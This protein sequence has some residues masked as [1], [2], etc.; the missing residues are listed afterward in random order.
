MDDKVQPNKRKYSSFTGISKEPMELAGHNAAASPGSTPSRRVPGATGTALPN[1]AGT[2]AAAPLGLKLSGH[3]PKATRTASINAS[4]PNATTLPSLRPSG[5]APEATGIA[6]PNV[7]GTSAPTGPDLQELQRGIA[8]LTQQ[9]RKTNNML[10]TISNGLAEHQERISALERPQLLDP[11]RRGTGQI[12]EPAPIVFPPGRAPVVRPSHGPP[13]DFP[14]GHLMDF[15]HGPSMSLSLGAPIG[16]PHGSS[17]GL[18]LGAPVSFS[19]GLPNVQATSMRGTVP[20][21]GNESSGRLHLSTRNV[22]ARSDTNLSAAQGRL[23]STVRQTASG[24]DVASSSGTLE[25]RVFPGLGHV[26]L[27]NPSDLKVFKSLLG[28]SFILDLFRSTDK[29]DGC[30]VYTVQRFSDFNKLLCRQRGEETRIFEHSQQS[31]WSD[32]PAV[33][34]LDGRKPASPVLAFP[35][36]VLDLGEVF[37]WKRCAETGQKQQRSSGFHLVMDV[38]RPTK[39][40]WLVYRYHERHPGLEHHLDLN[41]AY[42]RD[43]VWHPFAAAAG[44]EFDSALIFTSAAH[45]KGDMKYDGFAAVVDLVKRTGRVRKPTFVEPVLEEVKQEIAK[46]WA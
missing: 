14:S 19:D 9:S 28:K 6:I 10:S 38:T 8:D 45:L 18:S 43:P 16:F 5:H 36:Y 21:G 33:F 11:I 3:T 41:T 29:D 15:S 42:K 39:P 34:E 30:T 12:V 1:A 17:M 46:G 23:A 32:V 31:V 27:R 4:D 7:S 20:R 40:L 37:V 22:G 26:D 44:I 35:R 24:N 25:S 2:G 13:M